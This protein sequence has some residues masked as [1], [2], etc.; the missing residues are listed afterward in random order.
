[1]SNYTTAIQILQ[2]VR[3]LEQSRRRSMPVNTLAEEFHVHRR[4]VIR[5]L[6]A[7]ES[8]WTNEVGEAHIR[9]EHHDGQAWA[10]LTRADS[11]IGSN[12]FQYAAVYAA[13]RLLDVGGPTVLHTSSSDV[14]ERLEEGLSDKHRSAIPRVRQAFHYLSFAPK[15]Y[16]DADDAL[17]QLIRALLQHRLVHLDYTDSKGFSAPIVI[18]PWT[19]V[20]YRDGL[21][22]LG[23]AD[24]DHPLHPFALERMSNVVIGSEKF[25]I[26]LDY[27]PSDEFGEGFGIWRPESPPVRVRIAFEAHTAATVRNRQWRG[28]RSLETGPDGRLILELEVPITPE[29]KSWVLHWGATVEVLEPTEL[30]DG[31][32]EQLGR[33]LARYDRP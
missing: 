29:L 32:R 21:Y 28:F 22:L 15:D 5:W 11:A 27:D 26:P 4:T 2:L 19:L 10:T 9:R 23:R 12:I 8:E 33:A 25:D 18:Q 31:V 6:E 14:V 1:M 30:R 7:L 24:L 3:R 20:M 17:D 13:T 16:R